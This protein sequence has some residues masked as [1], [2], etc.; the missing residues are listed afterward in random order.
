M[1]PKHL[2]I[3]H[4]NLYCF[5]LLYAPI[6][7]SRV[8]ELLS[9]MTKV[10]NLIFEVLY[11]NVNCFEFSKCVLSATVIFIEVALFEILGKGFHLFLEFSN[12]S[13]VFLGFRYYKR[14]DFFFYIFC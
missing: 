4:L 12:L 2:H 9:G 7:Q 3:T 8:A 14:C 13:I 6:N 11:F 5:C 1:I 10:C